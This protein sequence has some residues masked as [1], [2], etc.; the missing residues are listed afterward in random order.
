MDSDFGFDWKRLGTL[1]D[2]ARQEDWGTSGDLT[3]ALLP[4]SALQSRGTW[5]LVAREPGRFCGA[6]ILPRLLASLAPDIEAAWR[7][8]A[9]DGRPI[10][11]GEVIARFTGPIG[12]MLSAE[13]TVLN[14]LQRL[15]GVATL[16]RRY[17][18]AVAGLPVGIYDT[19]KTTPG[20][21][22]LEKYA[23]RCGGGRNHRVGLYDAVLIK[24]NHLAAMEDHGLAHAVSAMLGRLAQERAAPAFVEVECD[25]LGQ[26]SELLK[27]VGV[28]V[29]LL[30]NFS[31]SDLREAV[32]LRDAAV[33]RGKVALEASG[34]VT[35]ETVRAVAETDV[36]RIAVGA[37]THSARFLDLGLDAV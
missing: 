34:G 23:V 16:T 33:L 8:P 32:R 5:E 15:S 28:D 7:R 36:E 4:E 3:S 18:D 29:I 6:E 13:R 1:F 24:D 26:V 9:P 19:R 20:L 30:D 37:L 21:R 27:V 35:L 22:E 10:A 2:L 17:V 11:A 25:S 12:Q 31:V 14:F